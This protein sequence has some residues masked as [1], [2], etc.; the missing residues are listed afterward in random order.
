MSVNPIYEKKFSVSF[1]TAI[2]YTVGKIKEYERTS[3]DKAKEVV[4]HLKENHTVL[5]VWIDTFD[6]NNNKTTVFHDCYINA[7]GNIIQN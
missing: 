7:F 1:K 2:P 3:I 5:S 6:E 4:N